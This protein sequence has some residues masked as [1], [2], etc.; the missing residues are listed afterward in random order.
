[1]TGDVSEHVMLLADLFRICNDNAREYGHHYREQC[2]RLRWQ[3]IRDGHVNVD[4][5]YTKMKPA[6]DGISTAMSRWTWWTN[7]AARVGREIQGE[8][9]LAGL[10]INPLDPWYMATLVETVNAARN[11]NT[12]LHRER[13]AREAREWQGRLRAA[14]TEPTIPAPRVQTH[15]VN[16]EKA[17]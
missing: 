17:S 8:L 16:R 10:G 4:E 7:E 12:T 1:M 3:I 15:D 6:D 9:A 2:D 5:L 13:R 14:L 11:A